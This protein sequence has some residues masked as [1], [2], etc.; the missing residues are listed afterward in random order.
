V[1]YQKTLLLPPN[2]DT[3]YEYMALYGDANWRPKLPPEAELGHVNYNRLPT[4]PDK[5]NQDLPQ[6]GSNPPAAAKKRPT[7]TPVKN[8]LNVVKP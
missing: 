2:M 4:N 5:A 3:M 8:P 7:I 6:L 1:E